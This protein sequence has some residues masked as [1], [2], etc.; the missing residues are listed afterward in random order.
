ME[1]TPL[2]AIPTFT[3]RPRQTNKRP[4]YLILAIIIVVLLFLGYKAIVSGKSGPQTNPNASPVVTRH[5][6]PYG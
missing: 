5:T 6:H 2:E 1:E 3:P 4:A